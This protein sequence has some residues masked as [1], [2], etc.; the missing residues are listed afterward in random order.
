MG[1]KDQLFD[2]PEPENQN[3]LGYAHNKELFS[4]KLIAKRRTY[5]IDAKENGVGSKFLTIT[6]SRKH[7]GV[8]LRNRIYVAEEDIDSF[9]NDLAAVARFVK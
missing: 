9:L 2:K 6:E 3:P 5:Y 8:H 1:L 7:N 4:A